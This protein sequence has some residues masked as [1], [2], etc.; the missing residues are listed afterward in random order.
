MPYFTLRKFLRDSSS[1]WISEA[2]SQSRYLS[3]ER[4]ILQDTDS[5]TSYLSVSEPDIT[6]T[7]ISVVTRPLLNLTSIRLLGKNSG[8]PTGKYKHTG[9]GS[10]MVYR[11]DRPKAHIPLYANVRLYVMKTRLAP[12]LGVSL[13]ADLSKD[14]I[15][16]YG[17]VT[18][19]G[20]HITKRN[21]EWT[22]GFSF[23]YPKYHGHALPGHY[24]SDDNYDGV[25]T[26]K[27]E[28]SFWESYN[29]SG[30]ITVGYSF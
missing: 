29:L 15:L 14:H 8:K 28:Y 4:N 27:V 23:S 22:F 16:P 7:Y 1:M 18:L 6:M 9:K 13:G 20:R 19:G 10:A 11:L 12:Y 24:S 2:R 25:S 26:S 21:R 30:G 5:T 17:N 3:L